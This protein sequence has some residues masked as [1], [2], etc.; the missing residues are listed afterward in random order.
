MTPASFA[1]SYGGAAD[2]AAGA[3]G[4]SR[5]TVLTQWA[6]ETGWCAPNSGCP[7]SN[8]AGITCHGG[9]S[10]NQAGF[11]RYS[12]PGAFAADYAGVLHN[13]LYAG[14]LASAG[15]TLRLQMAALGASPWASSH[16]DAGG[17][18]GSSLMAL[19]GALQPLSGLGLDDLLSQPPP[20]PPPPPAPPP[21]VTP[22]PA[23]IGDVSAPALLL[24]G[25]G[26][27]AI[28]YAEHRWPG[29]LV[30]MLHRV[31]A[32]LRSWAGR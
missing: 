11:C 17:G 12:D 3:T 29:T 2:Q 19:Y 18:P 25:A 24:L 27:I 16:Y 14:V 31:D 9:C 15:T 30:G 10:C 7:W 13:G 8:L 20:G 23:S 21:T 28:G 1:A 26:A 5:W 6:L 4:L 22:A 32:D